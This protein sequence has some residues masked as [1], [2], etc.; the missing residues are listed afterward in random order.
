MMGLEF[1]Q[2]EE[3]LEGPSLSSSFAEETRSRDQKLVLDLVLKH[4]PRA[5]FSLEE[6][7]SK[8]FQKAG[9]V[10]MLF[11]SGQFGDFAN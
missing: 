3:K 1:K 10:L 8:L 2:C 6:E 7:I 11:I 9:I 4:S 5:T